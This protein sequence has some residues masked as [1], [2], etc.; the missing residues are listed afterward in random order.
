MS[1]NLEKPSASLYI[2]QLTAQPYFLESGIVCLLAL[3]ALALN[4]KMIREGL[5]FSSHDIR[6]H[7]AWLQHFSKQLS[8]GIWYPRWLAGT[9]FGYGSPT[10]VFY[11]PLVYYIGSALK[12]IGLNTEEAMIVLFIFPF[13]AAGLGFYIY[14]YSRWGRIASLIGALA[15]MTAPY[16]TLNV[17]VRG[18]LA[19]TW[20]LIWIPVGLWLT[21]KAISHSKWRVALAV[22]FTVFALTHV[23]NLLVCTISWLLYTLCFLL[24]HSWKAVAKNVTYVMIG[25]GIASPYLLPAIIEKS[26]V[27]T[28]LTR[29]VSGGFSANFIGIKLSEKGS[30]VQDYIRPIFI[31]ELLVSLLCLS[32]IL[33]LSRQQ[34]GRTKQAFCWMFF[35]LIL[36]FLMNYHST[37]IWQASPTLQMIQF[38]WRLLGLFSLGEAILCGIAVHRISQS[39]TPQ[40]QFFL[41]II[42]AL[43]IGNIIFCHRLYWDKPT[44]HNPGRDVSSKEFI[45]VQ[46]ALYD[47]YTDKLIDLNEFRPSLKNHDSIPSPVIGQP[48]VSLVSGKASIQ[49]NQWASYNRVFNVIVEETATIKVRTYNYPAWHLYIN[50]KPHPI[51]VSSDGTI[52]LTLQPGF[53]A[54]EL[55]YLWTFPFTVGIII[56][57]ISI[58]TLILLWIQRLKSKRALINEI[59]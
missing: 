7:I 14:G 31:Y 27:K 58:A 24:N 29:K 42:I 34:R 11:P 43:I 37:P 52:E 49:I 53:S 25:L 9:N 56:S 48:P 22:F 47:P 54:V 35:L 38:P 20:S 1:S 2:R 46:K 57:I 6:N 30:F 15:Y 21:D 55:H 8:E 18:A 40:K 4:W 17:S 36:S 39:Q 59:R 5:F 13:F 33:F 23:P 19:E 16:I 51:S 28:D 3:V 32:I 12:L 10:F 50:K 26:L 44:F 41:L 45:Q